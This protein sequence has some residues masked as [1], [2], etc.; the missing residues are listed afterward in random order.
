MV[1]RGLRLP[2]STER[3]GEIVLLNS[4]RVSRLSTG[5]GDVQNDEEDDS[6]DPDDVDFEGDVEDVEEVIS[7][8][9]P[10]REE[11]R[12]GQKRRYRATVKYKYMC[13]GLLE[14][15]QEEMEEAAWEKGLRKPNRTEVIDS[16][17][18][19]GLAE[20]KNNLFRW[21]KAKEKI[22]AHFAK[23]KLRKAKSV[24]SGG[25]SKIP[26]TEAAVKEKI[27]AKRAAG[28]RVSQASVKEWLRTL[29][30]ELE[31]AAEA[32]LKFSEN[33]FRRAFKRMGVTLRRISSS[34]A[35]KNEDAA[36]FGR[37]F[38]RELMAL[39]EN[40]FSR[41]F[42]DASWC[43]G[44]VKHSVF[45]FFPPEY[46]FACDEVPFNFAAD[47][48]TVTEH[49]KQAAVRTLRGTGKRFGTC[50]ITAAA[51]GEILKFV[52][53]FKGTKPKQKEVERFKEFKHCFVAWSA[54]SYINESIW[55]DLVIGRVMFDHLH[56][57]YGVDWIKRRYLHLSD[58]HSSHQ[59]A[60]A[61]AACRRHCIF[62]A[63]TPPNFTSHFSMI[64]DI[65]GTRLR[66]NVYDK[67]EEYEAAYFEEHPDG[68]GGIAA[69]QR[70]YLCVKWWNETFAEMSTETFRNMFKESA[71]RNGLFV[72]PVKP[73]DTT[74]LPAPVRFRDTVY[75]D[76]G[77]IVYMPEHPD[78][79]KQK[80]YAFGFPEAVLEEVTKEE[81]NDAICWEQAEDEDFHSLE[82]ECVWMGDE[83]PDEDVG[84][85]D[86]EEEEAL[87][88]HAAVRVAE[89]LST[90]TR[91]QGRVVDQYDALTL[92][93]KKEKKKNQN[94]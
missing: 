1:E 74:Y 46:V 5:S 45:G 35:V 81:L 80:E 44:I 34:K 22:E 48:K 73:A 65:V 33:Y 75:Q 28:L 32:S 25:V 19:Q 24:G 87:H 58:N 21:W 9:E 60:R 6:Y 50:V 40:G 27:K 62:P 23:K 49:G 37:F 8:G 90:L 78:F 84:M 52:I 89:R 3:L 94:E 36:L 61:L 12:R 63:F 91:A 47:G 26:R 88:E 59:T 7:A 17:I 41:F 71:K 68:D 2:V 51:S 39:R 16:V 31:P 55:S 11:Q 56:S 14:K 83:M 86:S 72:T 53:I 93:E 4:L 15:A 54:T 30:K 38:C 77:E 18:A 13:I 82:E 85:L 92:A 67:A 76:F 70:R 20:P 66:K 43:E 69:D 64:D 42:P 29:A 79:N 57:K 10:V